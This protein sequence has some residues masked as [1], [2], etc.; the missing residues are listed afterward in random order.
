MVVGGAAGGGYYVG[1][2]QR[3]VGQISDDTAITARINSHYLRDPDIKSRDIDVD[4]YQGV[5][6]L[7]GTVPSTQALGRAI[8]IAKATKGVKQVVSKLSV[9]PGQ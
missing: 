6:T 1:K 5:V 2:D 7:H 4:T 8:A 3:S 9:A